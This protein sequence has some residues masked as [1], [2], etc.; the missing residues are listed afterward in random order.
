MINTLNAVFLF[1]DKSPKRQRFFE[2]ILKNMAPDILK[3]KLVGLCKTRWVEQ[4]TRFDTFYTMYAMIDRTKDRITA[5]RHDI[6]DDTLSKLGINTTSP[7]GAEPRSSRQTYRA[8]APST[9]PKEYHLRNLAIPFVDYLLTEFNSRFNYEA[10]KGV[11]SSLRSEVKEWQRYWSSKELNQLLI[12]LS[13]IKSC[14]C[15]YFS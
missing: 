3:T 14:R 10:R 6:E 8:N 5:L 15:R 1:F 13:S 2:R 11:G 7:R 12:N 4:H 9:C